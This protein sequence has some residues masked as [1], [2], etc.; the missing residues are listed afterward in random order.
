MNIVNNTNS[1]NIE[2]KILFLYLYNILLFQSF[3][4]LMYLM[5]TKQIKNYIKKDMFDID[6]NIPTIKLIIPKAF[7]VP[8]LLAIVTFKLF[9]V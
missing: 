7:N 6:I 3:I 2:I 4:F 1:K 5:Y 9:L 8:L